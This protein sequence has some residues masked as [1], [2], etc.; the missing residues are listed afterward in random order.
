MKFVE[1]FKHEITVPDKVPLWLWQV[2]IHTIIVVHYIHTVATF[3]L[4]IYPGINMTRFVCYDRITLEAKT[5]VYFI[6]YFLCP[7]TKC[8]A[9]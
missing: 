1:S 7:P 5:N 4:I 3:C 9:P 2:N 6:I 8:Y